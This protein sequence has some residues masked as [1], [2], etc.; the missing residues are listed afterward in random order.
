M[1]D[2][3]HRLV[4]WA[5]SRGW[6]VGWAG[7]GVL[8]AALAEIKTR[9]RSGEV[10]EAFA[11][12]N[13][14]FDGG[15]GQA[16]RDDGT[17][18]VLVIVTPRSACRI[19]FLPGGRRF[20]ALLPPTYERYRPIFE[21]VRKELEQDVLPGARVETLD[22]PLKLLAARLGLVRYGRT[23]VTYAPSIGSYLQMLGYLT[24][25]DLPAEAARELSL[26]HI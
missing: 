16:Q 7:I 26:I 17:W 6:L 18:R 20:D 14:S 1:N 13:L 3:K 25:A 8:R 22:A 21:D 11:H 9:R 4:E 15:D 2:V 5:D 23:N 24:D 10:P 19:G 12:D